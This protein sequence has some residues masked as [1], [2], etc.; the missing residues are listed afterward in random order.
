MAREIKNGM[1]VRVSVAGNER[2]AIAQD[3]VPALG[4]CDVHLVDDKGNT[5]AILP[6]VPVS[7]LRQAKLPEIPEARRP[8][9]IIAK[10]LEYL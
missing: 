10:R 6:K 2:T 5:S 8:N 4:V 7:E 1:W 9:D 3:L